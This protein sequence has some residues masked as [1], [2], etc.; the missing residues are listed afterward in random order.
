M[1]N[2]LSNT[3]F[4]V[5]MGSSGTTAE[6]PTNLL[7]G[8]VF[9]DTDLGHSVTYNGTDW[10]NHMESAV[11]VVDT[12]ADLSLINTDEVTSAYAKG[13]SIISDHAGGFFAYEINR[14]GENDAGTVFD[15]WVRQYQEDVNVKWFGA[16]GDGITDD[17]VAFTDALNMSTR[18][19]VPDG[20]YVSDITSS[21]IV[22]NCYGPGKVNNGDDRLALM[23]KIGRAD[24]SSGSKL[25]GFGGISIGDVENNIKLWV[26]SPGWSY[27]TATSKGSP[28]IHEVQGNTLSTLA[29]TTVGSNIV[30]NH[31]GQ[32][33]TEY[34]DYFPV[35][36]YNKSYNII[37]MNDTVITLENT[38]S[39]DVSFTEEITADLW[40]AVESSRVR[41]KVDQGRFYTLKVDGYQKPVYRFSSSVNSGDLKI[42]L[43]DLTLATVTEILD[44][45]DPE[46]EWKEY[47]LDKTYP[48]GEYDAVMETYWEKTAGI[49]AKH[50]QGFGDEMA[51]QM[52]SEVDGYHIRSGY[53]RDG[54][55]R[56]VSIE[57]GNSIMAMECPYD[58]DAEGSIHFL[59]NINEENLGNLDN[60]KKAKVAIRK[61]TATPSE[62]NGTDMEPILR[63]WGENAGTNKCSMDVENINDSGA[64]NIQGYNSGGAQWMSIQGN[65]EK[66]SLLLGTRDAVYNN[67]N[68]ITGMHFMPDVSESYDIGHSA[69]SWNKVYAK[70]YIA[71]GNNG[72]SGSFTS[73]DGKTITVTGGIITAIV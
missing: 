21:H 22:D 66:A 29:T 12:I 28:H 19:Y 10:V 34:R 25:K 17:S 42:I 58:K 37:E 49:V 9:F 73:N 43:P 20:Y 38:D 46:T 13:H 18:I 68:I 61:S 70:R 64:P 33:Y 32:D 23:D 53:G 47:T 55:H 31:A 56:P 3:D 24:A 5:S 15:G 7:R 69:Y 62:T 30:T 51:F 72:I 40:Q 2:K 59:N 27:F 71:Q 16:K 35:V 1:I 60:L 63:L 36:F 48:D 6:R 39:S 65:T 57:T 54:I 41:L 50:M 26:G 67:N 11:V 45:T 4:K 14:V 44:A 8:S 52:V